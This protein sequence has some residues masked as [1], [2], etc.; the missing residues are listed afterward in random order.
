M[1]TPARFLQ[2]LQILLEFFFAF[3]GCAVDALQHRPIFIPE[4]NWALSGSYDFIVGDGARLTPRV[5]VYGQSEIC[6]SIVSQVAC[7]ASHELVNIRLEWM[8]GDG[9]WTIAGGVTNLTD[10]EYMLNIFDLT[11]FGQNTVEGQPGRPQ[12]WY[13]E[14]GRNF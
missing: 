13:L 5:D 12:E 11:P 6:S 9:D 4:H 7:A 1:V 3:P 14:F 10:E 2:Q 8:S